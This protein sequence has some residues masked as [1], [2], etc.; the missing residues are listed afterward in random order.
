VSAVF[1]AAL[2]VMGGFIASKLLG[3]VRN[4]VIGYQYGA[5][6]EYELF[7]AAIAVPDTLFQ[8][9]AGGTVSAAFIPVFTAYLARGETDKAW[10]LASSLI[11]L[12][13]LLIGAMALALALVAP[14]LMEVLVAGWT[15]AE[16]QQ[17][18]GL[19]RIMMACAAIFAVSALIT[20]AL[21]G[22]RRFAL[23]AA[24][25][26]MYNLSLMGGAVL[27]RPWGVEGLA[28]S[29][30]VGAL[31]HLAV[32]VPGLVAI[33]MRYAPTLGLAL[34][35]TREVARLMGPRVLTLA[36]S[37]LTVL[38]SVALASFLVEGSVAYL[39]Y[40]WLIIMV[41][42]GVFGMGIATAAFPTLAE[43]GAQAR[44][45]EQRQTF[46]VT[47][48]LILYLT[49]PAAL[50]LIVLAHPIVALLLERGAFGPVA[51][52]ATA[53]ALT[54]YAL[55]LPA[56]ASIEIINRVFYAERDTATPF[57]VAM[58][59]AACSIT[60]GIL[61]MRTDLSFGG[62]ALANSIGAIFEA[63]ILGAILH[64]RLR[65]IERGQL[66]PFVW[67]VALAAAAMVAATVVLVGA[68]EPRVDSTHWTGPLVL[69]V[70]AIAVGAISY[71][72]TSLALGVE[73]VRRAAQLSI[74]RS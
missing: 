58:V 55:G 18:A 7:L 17:T 41:P 26:L 59:G 63:S 14:A 72:G 44:T 53:F 22:A 64:R 69:V 5:S 6:R 60:L 46:L 12:A 29:A 31:L 37:Q 54:W 43:Q 19:A 34:E 1:G 61:L 52:S 8:V 50:G 4:I 25:P 21:N 2:I 24:A 48:R 3:L 47:L 27:L 74:R 20:S 38:V 32:Q 68:L 33:G 66:A 15:P 73:D 10:R 51:T 65:W 57:L 30:V 56:H 36:V 67:R 16:Q 23:S 62:L 9:L 28:L 40:A 35:G 11:T 39:S 45:G 49:I 42:L 71:V 13:I 70:A